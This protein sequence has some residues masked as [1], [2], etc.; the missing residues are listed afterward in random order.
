MITIDIRKYKSPQKKM[1]AKIYIITVLLFLAYG[2]VYSQKFL[3]KTKMQASMGG[4]VSSDS[5]T[6][7]LLRS[8]QFGLVPLKSGIGFLNFNIE[9][10]LLILRSDMVHLNFMPVEE[11][12]YRDLPTLHLLLV[13]TCGQEMHYLCPNCKYPHRIG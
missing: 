3:Q 2:S 8:N 4:I 12:K 13:P 1:N 10:E 9:Q 7:F 11:E 6:P 5:T